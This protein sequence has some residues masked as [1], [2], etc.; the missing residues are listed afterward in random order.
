MIFK[1]FKILKYR[2]IIILLAVSLM[3]VMA[4]GSIRVY[5]Y[6]EHDPKFCV[7]C[8]V[9]AEPFASWETSVHKSIECHDCHYATIFEKNKML[10]QTVLGRPSKISRSPHEKILVSS[11]FCVR[12]HWDTHKEAPQISRSTGHAIH[13][14]KKGMEC[15]SCHAVE[16]HKFE[17][18]QGHCITCH[19]KNKV[20]LAKM[21]DLACT[22]CHQ[23]KGG[24]LIPD[25]ET[26]LT[27][28]PD[29]KP[30][31]AKSPGHGQFEC[32]TCHQ[33]HDP[34]KPAKNTCVNCHTLTMKRGKHPLHLEAAE[35]LTCH[36]PHRWRVNEKESRELCSQCHDFQ[37]L[38]S[39][40]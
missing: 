28:H 13:W 9:M 35:C 37:P 34:E 32:N 26:C 15:T 18:Q 5:D 11:S 30:A 1:N 38:K 7:T 4:Y 40:S 2:I 29:Q 36:Q 3:A 21:K 10:I 33:V 6:T 22:S 12:C 17:H 27:C 23:F 14:F 31:K 25:D 20:A 19:E 39:F 24:K 8:H 16:L